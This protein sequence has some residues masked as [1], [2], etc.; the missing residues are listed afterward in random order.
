MSPPSEK[1]S[2]RYLSYALQ[3]HLPL[4]AAAPAEC[5]AKRANTEEGTL[6]REDCSLT[7]ASAM[8]T[9]PRCWHCQKDMAWLCRRATVSLAFVPIF[10]GSA[11]KNKG[12]QLLLD[13][14]TDYLPSPGQVQ[15]SALVQTSPACCSNLSTHGSCLAGVQES[16]S[17]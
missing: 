7:S 4:Q 9:R 15:N 12:V 17:L 1:L 6:L 10:M 2:G 8:R 16:F 14:V 3:P 13:G 11:Y 5:S